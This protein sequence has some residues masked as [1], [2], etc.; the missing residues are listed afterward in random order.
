MYDLI[1][2]LLYKF[3][4]PKMVTDMQITFRMVWGQSIVWITV[5]FSIRMKN[6]RSATL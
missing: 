4:L 2:H 1:T 6:R 3:D 5:P